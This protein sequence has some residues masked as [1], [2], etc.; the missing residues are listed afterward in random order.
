MKLLP[1]HQG[2]AALLDRRLADGRLPHALLLVGPP[3]WGE[4]RF[5]NWLALRLLELDVGQD[6]ELIAHPD[7]RWTRPDGAVIKVD[8]VRELAAFAEGNPQVASR[9]VAVLED[10][11]ALN[12]NAANALLKTLEEPPAGVHLVLVSSRPGQLLPTIRSRCQRIVLPMHQSAAEEWL[13]QTVPTEALSDLLFEYGGAPMAIAAAHAAGVEPLLPLLRGVLRADPPPGLADTLA[14]R[15]LAD[16]TA[17]WYR[18]VAAGL[19]RSPGLPEL[20]D[21]PLRRLAEFERE[22][23]WVRAQLLASNSVNE[24]LMADRLLFLW[25]GL[26]RSGA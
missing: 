9:K 14:D 1:W 17:R 2:A 25:R 16:V 8:A 4:A 3:G 5:A 26:A 12:R 23:A 22:L 20:R 15:G 11:H 21:V 18:H 13:R 19:A 10:A 24:R 7:L 6:A